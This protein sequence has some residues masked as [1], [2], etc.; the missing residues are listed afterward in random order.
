MDSVVESGTGSG[1]VACAAG[2]AAEEMS[3]GQERWER[4]RL[5][6]HGKRA[7]GGSDDARA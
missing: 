1:G 2:E 7:R 4:D 3:G 6:R 5:G